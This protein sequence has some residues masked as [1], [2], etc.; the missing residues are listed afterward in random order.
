[1]DVD[2]TDGNNHQTN[3]CIVKWLLTNSI[4]QIAMGLGVQQTFPSRNFN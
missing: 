1:M 4:W 3:L 2:A